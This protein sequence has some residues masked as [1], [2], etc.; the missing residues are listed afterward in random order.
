MLSTI[1]TAYGFVFCIAQAAPG[2]APRFVDATDASGLGG[3]STAKACFVD[4]NA[5]GRPDVLLD[6]TQLFLNVPGDKLRFER[7]EHTG[8]PEP[9]RGDSISFADIDNDGLPDAVLVRYEDVNAKGYEAPEDPATR[10]SGWAKG[11][12]DGTFG[13]VRPLPLQPRTATAVAIGDA[14]LDGRLDLYFGNWYVKYGDTYEGYPNDL[15]LQRDD[16]WERAPLPT[17]G[18][19]FDD[20][21]DPGGRPTY[22]VRMID[23][24]ADGKPG[25]LDL[26]Y[27]RRWNRYMR[28]REAGYEDVAPRIGLDG[29]ANRDGVYPDWVKEKGREDE[30]PFR[31]N[32]NT[33]DASVGDIDNDGDLDLFV[34][35]IRHGWAGESSD[36]SRFLVQDDGRFTSPASLA[37][38]RDREPP[39]HWNL[40]DIFCAL[41]DLD[42]DGRLDL[43]LSSSDYPDDQRTRIFMQQPDGTFADE[44]AATG[45]DH[46]GSLQLSL[47]DVDLDGDLDV[48][49]GQGFN[50]LTKEQ[51]EG[52]KPL[53]RLYLNQAIEQAKG[54]LGN[55]LVLD[56]VG[57][58]EGMNRDAIGAVVRVTADLDGDPA[59]PSVTQMRVLDPVGGHEGKQDS[60]AVHVGLGRASAAE[61]VEITWPDAAHSQTLLRDVPAGRHTVRASERK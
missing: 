13:A 1:A 60:F 34:A 8:L 7:V 51:K 16:G 35:N 55:A 31:A 28:P 38:P 14:D 10:L 43:I 58:A 42:L 61:D 26:N 29:D 30:R 25:L 19:A 49:V 44:T 36:I 59:T 12:G 20:E 56:L 39:D 3:V 18:V 6:R 21:H 27:G 17:D 11:N 41:G 32:G 54:G 33:F 47:A 23:L 24:L 45:I 50:R 4:V 52:R 2:A 15:V 40:G 5:D 22:G 57:D 46:D 9:A 53:A 37:L 48:L